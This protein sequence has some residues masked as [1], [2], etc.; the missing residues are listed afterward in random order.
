MS[1]HN[2]FLVSPYSH[3]K[4]KMFFLYLFYVESY[5]PDTEAQKMNVY[6]SCKVRTSQYLE[7]HLNIHYHLK[8]NMNTEIATINNNGKALS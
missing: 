4:L 8:L 3:I 1:D 6:T 2:M 7:K 5:T